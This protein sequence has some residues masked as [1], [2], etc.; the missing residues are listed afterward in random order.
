MPS[1]LL[2][3]CIILFIIGSGDCADIPFVFSGGSSEIAGYSSD[4]LAKASAVSLDLEG[5]PAI[6]SPSDSEVLEF[7]VAGGGSESTGNAKK[8]VGDLKATLTARVEPENAAVRHEAV[9]LAARY[10]GDHSIDQISSIYGYL[11]G[12]AGETR[13]WSYVPDPRGVDYFMYA[14]ET[15]SIGKDAGCAGAGDCDDFAILMAA[16]V[17]SVGGTTRIILA[18]NNS[19][20]GHAYAEVYLGR[21]DGT[22]SQ[23]EQII[24]WLRKKYDTDRIYTHIDTDTKDVWL[25]LDWGADGKGNA[26]PGGPFYQGDKHIVLC[27]R[28][29]YEK[30]PLRLPDGYVV[31]TLPVVEK[32]GLIAV[33][34]N[35]SNPKLS[36]AFSPDGRILAAGCENGTVM[37]WDTESWSVIRMLEGHSS[38]VSSVAFSPDGRTLASGSGDNTIKL[39]DVDSGTEKRTIE[40]YSSLVYSVAF[41]PDGR[42]L[43]SGSNDNTIKLWDVDSGT[44]KRTLEGHSSFVFSVAFS[45]D[46]RTLASG[47]ND[48]TIKLWDV[49]SGTEKRTIEGHSSSVNSVAFSP[50]GRTLASGSYDNTIKLWDVDSGTEKRTIEGHSS[51]VYSV[52]FSPD[53]RTL[54]SGSADGTIKLW[55]VDSGTEKRTIESHS[56]GVNS[57]AF[58]PDGRTLASGSY[59]STIK[60][61]DVDSGTEK[62]TLDGHSSP[63]LSVAFSP[64]GRTL[65]SGSDDGTVRLWQMA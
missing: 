19:T 64:D 61:W 58:S 54:A 55:D 48:N 65:A 10:S 50:D 8:N 29:S 40:G 9:V 51:L 38:S 35:I 27:L 59:D 60:L 24:N 18:H 53:D 22:D 45:P 57:V 36:V 3:L 39:W 33:L 7:P 13:G 15:L 52:A 20:G 5:V 2:W 49:D 17:E 6:Y 14:N 12:G 56:K 11:K 16:L 44:E 43:A 47:S 63:V 30:T 1:K 31:R 23:V 32:Y 42:T 21:I 41:S 28:D 46:G 62:R 37:L 34:G 4:Q 25:N 26:H